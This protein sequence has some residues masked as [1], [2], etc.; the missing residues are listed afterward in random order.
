MHTTTLRL[1]AVVPFFLCLVT[2]WSQYMDEE[3][4]AELR[5]LE[6]FEE[7]TRLQV[8]KVAIL[9]A[10]TVASTEEDVDGSINYTIKLTFDRKVNT[11]LHYYDKESGQLRVDCYDTEPG[12]NGL[13][14]SAQG[15]INAVTVEKKKTSLTRSKVLTRVSVSLKSAPEYEAIENGQEFMLSIK[16][17]PR[18][19][20][21]DKD[22]G[23]KMQWWVIPVALGSAAGVGAV[24]FA[25][26]TPGKD[27][28]NIE[29]DIIQ[30]P[31]DRP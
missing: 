14:A 31:P 22:K 17:N 9:E 2:A 11:L 24:L 4:E 20:A 15:P 25:L 29:E 30:F 23:K 21:L 13:K 10:L 18:A 8:Q 3:V 19:E 28:N 12:G 6:G 26:K 16:W 1:L 27:V 7:D 5:K